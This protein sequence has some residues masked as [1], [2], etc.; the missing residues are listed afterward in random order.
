MFSF[1]AVKRFVE[2]FLCYLRCH[3]LFVC[4]STCD[5]GRFCGDKLPE[6]IISTDSRLWIEFRSSSNWVGKGFSAVYEGKHLLHD[7]A[8]PPFQPIAQLTER[9]VSH[10]SNNVLRSRI[11]IHSFWLLYC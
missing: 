6:P 3:S 10:T 4:L 8:A 1:L 5:P 9:M 7:L 2:E 11:N